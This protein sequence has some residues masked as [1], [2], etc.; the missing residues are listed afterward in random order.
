MGISDLPGE[1]QPYAQTIEAFG[2]S[3]FMRRYELATPEQQ[4]GMRLAIWNADQAIENLMRELDCDR[5]TAAGL[6]LD[7][8]RPLLNPNG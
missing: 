7:I 8:S 3:R 6:F 4:E 1:L 5:N 2:W